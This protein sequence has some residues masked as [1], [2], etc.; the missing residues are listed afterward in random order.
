MTHYALTYLGQTTA[1]MRKPWARALVEDLKSRGITGTI[2]RVPAPDPIVS[3]ICYA[4]HGPYNVCGSYKGPRSF[5]RSEVTCDVCEA[6]LG[7]SL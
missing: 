1:P 5:R 6:T 2:R 7:G 3:P 4:R